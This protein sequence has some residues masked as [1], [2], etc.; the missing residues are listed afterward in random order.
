MMRARWRQAMTRH[1][2]LRPPFV[3]VFVC[4]SVCVFLTV[5]NPELRGKIENSEQRAAAK[6]VCVETTRVAFAER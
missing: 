3:C 5:R 4:V 6:N 1:D 2:P